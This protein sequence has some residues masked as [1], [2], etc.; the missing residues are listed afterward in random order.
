MT[1]QVKHLYSETAG[2]RPPA[3]QVDVGQLWI[4]M[5]D[6]T[7]GTKKSDGQLATYAQLTEAERE[8]VRNAMPK[9]G[10]VSGVT[11]SQVAA[12]TETDAATI[13]DDSST[14]LEGTLTANEFHVTINKTTAHKNT[15]LVLKKPA[16]VTGSVRWDGVDLWLIGDSAPVF[17]DTQEE[18]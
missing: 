10:Q 7:I 11:V 6:S 9:T 12:A 18:K 14:V 16:G 8:A 1:L 13:D 4:N 2:N 5:G 17:G 15:K 3:E